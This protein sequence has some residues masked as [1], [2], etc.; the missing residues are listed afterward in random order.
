MPNVRWVT[1]TRAAPTT[2]HGA[3]SRRHRRCRELCRGAAGRPG[4]HCGSAPRRHRS[5]VRSLR[6]ASTPRRPP[7]PIRVDRGR[8]RLLAQQ[9]EGD[10]RYAVRSRWCVRPSSCRSA[11]YAAAPVSRVGGAAWLPV[12]PIP[13]CQVVQLED[14]LGR[15]CADQG[16]A[17]ASGSGTRRPERLSMT[18]LC[19]SRCSAVRGAV[20]RLPLPSSV[21]VSAPRFC[22]WLAGV[23]LASTARMKSAAARLATEP[24]TELTGITPDPTTMAIASVSP[25]RVPASRSGRRRGRVWLA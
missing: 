20:L 1:F 14:L 6:R 11:A 24:L 13:S 23:R 9:V 3:V 10:A 4:T 25:A 2:T 21:D 18:K 22:W 8:R 15:C 7:V 16:G 19:P 17:V 5:I 12:S